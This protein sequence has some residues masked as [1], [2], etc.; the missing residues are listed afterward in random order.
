MS[1]RYI[2]GLWMYLWMVCQF[3]PLMKYYFALKIIVILKCLI[4]VK[5]NISLSFSRL[6]NI[7]VY[8]AFLFFILASESEIVWRRCV[9]VLVG[10]CIVLTVSCVFI[11]YVL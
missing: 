3:T 1:G 10:K 2:Y 11:P 8:L 6:N 9:I 4:L 5:S 7:L